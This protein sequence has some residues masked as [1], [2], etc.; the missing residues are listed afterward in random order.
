MMVWGH[1]LSTQETSG[2]L[3]TVLWV[4]VGVGVQVFDQ[5]LMVIM[6]SDQNTV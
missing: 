5:A 6:G 2:L 1:Y 4:E 3:D